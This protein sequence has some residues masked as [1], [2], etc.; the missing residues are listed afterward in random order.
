MF[1]SRAWFSE[2]NIIDYSKTIALRIN[3]KFSKGKLDMTRLLNVSA[4]QNSHEFL[5]G[6]NISIVLGGIVS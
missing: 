5:S 6:I 3:I 1:E 4:S 2:M